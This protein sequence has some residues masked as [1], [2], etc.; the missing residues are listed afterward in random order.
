MSTPARP[1]TEAPL[2]PGLYVLMGILIL[3]WGFNW[4][5][6]K[7]A[8]AEMEPLRFRT[9]CLVVGAAGVFAVAWATGQGIRVPRDQWTRLI[10]IALLN[11]FI[12][13]V[14]SVY[15]LQ[16]LSSG[17][18]AI[19]AY[20]M[21][22]WAVLLSRWLLHEAI[23]P[24]RL[25]GLLL[26]LAGMAL[27]MVPGFA[28]AGRSLM[29]SFLMLVCALAWAMGIVAMKRWP[30]ALP[31]SSFTAWQ[32]TIA[33][34]PIAIAGLVLESGTYFPWEL[35][36]RAGWAAAYTIVLC[37]VLCQWIWVKLALVMPVAASTVSSLMN[38]VL[39]TLGGMWLLGETVEWN[40]YGALTLV[41]A[42]IVVV[43]WPARRREAAN[44][45]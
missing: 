19:L 9:A 42:A 21:P 28:A 4:P 20:T 29:G 30:V 14:F 26:G 41:C 24:R 43:L 2:S 7:I 8:L 36:P 5:I 22:L 25:V 39:G 10:L 17:R 33:A 40:D 13:N 6:M 45:G 31:P 1:N 27:L 23:T 11:F 34:V 3:L 16:L 37:Y 35:S 38:P 18:A 32:M 15:G 12:W 44:A